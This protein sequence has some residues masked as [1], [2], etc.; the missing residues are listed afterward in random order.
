[1]KTTSKAKPKK[2]HERRFNTIL[3]EV[4]DEIL[5]GIITG[6]FESS[7]ITQGYVEDVKKTRFRSERFNN[8]TIYTRTRKTGSGISRPE[9][10]RKISRD[11]FARKWKEVK[12][13][14][15]KRRYRIPYDGMVIELNVFFINLSGYCQ[16]EVESRNLKKLLSFVPPTWLG[17]EVT[18]DDHY[19]SYSLARH[20]LPREEL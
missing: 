20:G 12:Y 18:D 9:D 6:K 11:Y 8:H 16:S 3:S 7:L 1:M 5:V 14:L 4:P 15:Q 13:S 2:E 17:P 10:E 19:S